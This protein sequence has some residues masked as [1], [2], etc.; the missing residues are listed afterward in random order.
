[1]WFYRDVLASI[2]GRLNAAPRRHPRRSACRRQLAENP[3]DR[4]SGFRVLQLMPGIGATTAKGILEQLEATAGAASLADVRVPPRTA[5]PW[6]GFV[7]LLE[8][9]Q[10]GTAGWP[11]EIEAVR[12]WYEPHLER[13]YEDEAVRPAT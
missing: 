9:F 12:L 3:R 10:R 6:A 1:M 5:E 8:L 4:V 13:R 2:V 11:A 7:P